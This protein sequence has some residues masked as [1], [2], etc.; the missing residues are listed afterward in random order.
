MLIG[1]GQVRQGQQ[2]GSRIFPANLILARRNFPL[3]RPRGMRNSRV[4]IADH[5]NGT[6]PLADRV[7]RNKET[8]RVAAPSSG[9]TY[10]FQTNIRDKEHARS[11][12]SRVWRVCQKFLSFFSRENYR[13]KMKMRINYRVWARSNSKALPKAA[14]KYFKV[15]SFFDA[16]TAARLWK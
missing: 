13:R 16:G 14:S 3:P 2:R 5:R 7:A 12:E 6:P 1:G 15:P 8:S 10:D 11:I 4:V 9:N